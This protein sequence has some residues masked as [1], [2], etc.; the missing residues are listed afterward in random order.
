MRWFCQF[1]D[2]IESY[3]NTPYRSSLLDSDP[4]IF[5]L[6][7]HVKQLFISFAKENIKGLSGEMMHEY[8]HDNIIPSLINDEKDETGEV[9]TKNDLLK[10]Y[11]LTKLS[12]DTIYNWMAVFGFKY[13]PVKKSYYVD[14]HEKPDPVIPKVL[15]KTVHKRRI[16][17]L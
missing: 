4:K 11:G 7:P 9:I 14:G 1:R 17:V 10:Q 15:H 12:L 3:I 13:S 16:T 5:A 8:F 2:N 6:N